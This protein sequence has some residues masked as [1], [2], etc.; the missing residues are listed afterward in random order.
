MKNISIKEI[1]KNPNIVKFDHF[2][3]GKFYYNVYN[4]NE[5]P[6]GTV[7]QFNVPLEEI[8]DS[9]FNGTDKAIYFMR[10]IRKSIEKNEF[11]KIN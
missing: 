8:G 11:I 5:T 7:Y 9:T 10:F 2:R 1:V 6:E 4:P 3:Q